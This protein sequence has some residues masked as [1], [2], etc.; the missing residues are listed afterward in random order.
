MPATTPIEEEKTCPICEGPRPGVFRVRAR[1]LTLG[2][3][4]GPL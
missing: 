1:H 2:L 4:L 3:R